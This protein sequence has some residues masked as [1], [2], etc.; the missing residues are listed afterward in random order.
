MTDYAGRFFLAFIHGGWA[1]NSL[2]EKLYPSRT[3]KHFTMGAIV[4]HLTW[5]AIFET[6]VLVA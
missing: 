5:I 2:G 4:T 3:D 6:W 1:A